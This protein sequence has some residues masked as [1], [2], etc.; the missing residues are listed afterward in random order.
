LGLDRELADQEDILLGHHVSDSQ[1]DL[2]DENFHP[3]QGTFT[4][5]VKPE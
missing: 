1:N 2:A 5:G 4:D 3:D